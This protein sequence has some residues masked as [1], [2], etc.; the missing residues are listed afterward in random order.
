MT[1]GTKRN[2]GATSFE[3][4]A[5]ADSFYEAGLVCLE[6]KHPAQRNL[7]AGV[8]LYLFCH[9]VE[10]ALKAYLIQSGMKIERLA[11]KEFGHNLLTLLRQAKEDGIQCHCP[12]AKRIWPD[13]TVLNRVY[14][15]KELEY[16]PGGMRKIIAPRDACLVTY[17][18]LVELKGSC[19]VSRPRC[20]TQPA[21]E[22]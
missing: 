5:Q 15:A 20:P 18:L 14:Q 6:G 3:L 13:L 2:R 1:S 7:G 21:E 22:C 9:A 16:P 4:W 11:S 17:R 10:L 8:P 12:T 19:G